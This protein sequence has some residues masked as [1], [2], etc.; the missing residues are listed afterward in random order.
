M[1]VFHFGVYAACCAGIRIAA[2][3]RG[4][5]RRSAVDRL[6]MAVIVCGR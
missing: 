5:R 6:W 1:L 4:A 3:I 2:A